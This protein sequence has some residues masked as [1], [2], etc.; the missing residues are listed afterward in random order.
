MT[1]IIVFI[2]WFVLGV[3]IGTFWANKRRRPGWGLADELNF[4]QELWRLMGPRK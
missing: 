2:T 1:D 4:W 3:I